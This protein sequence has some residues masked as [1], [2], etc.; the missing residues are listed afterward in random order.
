MCPEA[1]FNPN[2]NT[3]ITSRSSCFMYEILRLLLFVTLVCFHLSDHTQK[4]T[5][6]SQNFST[7][8]CII[9]AATNRELGVIGMR[10]RGMFNHD[11]R[12]LLALVLCLLQN[13]LLLLIFY[14]NKTWLKSFLSLRTRL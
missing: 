2:P 1:Y 6:F 7:C 11:N 14:N 9:S 10:F 5:H 12:Y 13:H 4:Y 8:M 3:T